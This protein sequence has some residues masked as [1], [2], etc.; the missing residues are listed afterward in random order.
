MKTQYKDWVIFI[1]S[2]DD[3][4]YGKGFEAEFYIPKN[5]GIKHYLHQ[6]RYLDKSVVKT[7]KKMYE[8]VMKIIDNL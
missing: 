7:Q 2:I 6:L 1:K 4:Y 5:D 8:Y 3:P